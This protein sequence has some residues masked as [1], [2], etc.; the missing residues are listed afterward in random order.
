MNICIISGSPRKNANSLKL[1]KR[2]ANYAEQEGQ[3]HTAIVS[4]ENYD[5][6]LMAQGSVNI[7]NLS[8]FQQQLKSSMESADLIFLIS[9][10]YNWMPSAEVVNFFHQMGD[11]PFASMWT[12][13]VFAVAG[14]SNGRGGRFPTIQMTYVLNKLIGFMNFN[15]LVAPRVFESQFTQTAIN[16]QGESMGNAEYDKGFVQYLESAMEVARRWKKI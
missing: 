10:E 9:P 5:I 16:D 14:V 11:K 13:K 15:S 2:I 8:P 12:E 3:H 1:A 4:F 6:P 7:L